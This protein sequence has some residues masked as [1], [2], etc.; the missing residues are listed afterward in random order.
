[1]RTIEIKNR[2][3]F[4]LLEEELKENKKVRF[5]IKG[6]SMYP[7]LRDEKDEVLLVSCDPMQI[8]TGD[9]VLFKF[10]GNYILHRFIQKEKHTFIF[11]GDNVWYN[12][13]YCQANDL[14]GVVERVYRKKGNATD[15]EF[16]EVAP[17][18][19]RWHFIVRLNQTKIIIRRGIS[20]LFHLFH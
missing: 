9:I 11:K 7:L 20:R 5:R 1:M 3:F 4:P 13:E 12:K 8:H 19:V 6:N 2:V 10:K 17:D 14:V 16:H 15:G 18:S